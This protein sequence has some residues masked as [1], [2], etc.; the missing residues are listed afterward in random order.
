MRNRL[1]LILIGIAAMLFAG[2]YPSES[3]A[4][5][6]IFSHNTKAH[7]EG[8]YSSCSSCHT[9]P[10]KNW[11]AP[12]RDKR[13]PFPDVTTFPYHTSCFGCHTRDIYSRGGVFCGTCHVVA[14]MRATGGRG[15]LA[16][17]VRSHPT[18][19]T[20]LFPHNI[21]QDLIASNERKSAYAPAHFIKTSFTARDGSFVRQDDKAR[22]SFY[23]CAICHETAAQMPKFEP[24]KLSE[25]KSFGVL[26]A[27]TFEAP[28]MPAFF[29]DSPDSHASCFNCH[30]QFKNLPP[31]KQS[32]AGCHELTKP[33]ID[34]NVIPRYSLK[35]NHDR[36]DHAQKD[37]MSCHLRIA[38]N[39]D[40]RTLKDAD[41]PIMA[42]KQCHATQEEQRFK[43]I[44]NIEV[45]ARDASLAKNEQPVF[46]CTYCHTSAIGRFETPASHRK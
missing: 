36:V 28:I 37:C 21:H 20:T 41:V 19:F 45:D 26:V 11:S 15:V 46:Q 7:K 3:T 23:N 27:D 29:K 12:R 43:N 22:P 39:N 34:K 17:P 14:S 32:C 24:R 9:L 42:C 35:F 8:K 5:R 40:I 44:L 16:F 31:G 30:Y 10:E 25:A 2:G 1:A 18:Q 38:Q 33:F 4:Q 13:E 6:R